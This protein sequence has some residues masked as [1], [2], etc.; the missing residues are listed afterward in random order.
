MK[1]LH[2]VSINL[3]WD[4]FPLG[5]PYS[6]TV[7]WDGVIERFEKRLLLVGNG[8]TYLKVVNYS[9]QEHLGKSSCLFYVFVSHSCVSVGGIGIGQ[10]TKKFFVGWLEGR[11][12]VS[13]YRLEEGVQAAQER[14]LGIRKFRHFNQ[15]L[16]GKWL[17]RFSKERSFMEEGDRVQILCW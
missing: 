1:D 17:W 15:A 8:S 13:S 9:Y 14:G 11:I 3:E 2:K 4:L 6:V 7:V 10:V 12:Q 5:A 16:T